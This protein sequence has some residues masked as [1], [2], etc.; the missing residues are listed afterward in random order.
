MH[1]S[2]SRRFTGLAFALATTLPASIAYA[3]PQTT[4]HGQAPIVI[5]HRGASGYLPE[6]TLAGYELAVKMGVDYIEPDLHLTRDGQLV[7]IHDA[8]LTRTTNVADVFA[9]RNGGYRVADFTLAELKTLEMKFVGT[10]KPSYPGFT[11]T[12]ADAFRIPTFQEVITLAQRLSLET[13]REIG[14]YPE[15]KAGGATMEDL[16]LKTLAD[17]GYGNASKLFIQSFSADTIKNLHDKQSALGLDFQLVVLGSA[18]SLTN[19]GLAA[20]AAYADGV[21]PSIS[22]LGEAF[23]GAAHDAGLLVH[24]YTFSRPDPATALPQYTQFFE[25]G[26]DGV[27]SNYPDLALIARDEFVAAVPE[28]SSALLALLGVAGIAAI[29][30]R[31]RGAAALQQASAAVPA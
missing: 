28:P 21:G 15:A 10:A 16:V 13:G 29:A 26:L 8:T 6:H 18:T 23:I 31:R 12:S 3:A 25:W 4:L 30:R 2:F 7:A 5:A 22:G 11:P 27:F 20:I 24:A 1:L 19:L 17:N 14:I 9:Q